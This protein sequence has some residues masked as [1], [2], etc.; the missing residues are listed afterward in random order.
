MHLFV[1]SV[2]ENLIE[3]DGFETMEMSILH[4]L[5]MMGTLTDPANVPFGG[6]GKVLELVDAFANVLLL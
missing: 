3:T 2:S 1:H 6:N 4:H 5:S